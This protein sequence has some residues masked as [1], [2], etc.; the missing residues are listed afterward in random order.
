MEWLIIARPRVGRTARNPSLAEAPQQCKL[1]LIPDQARTRRTTRGGLRRFRVRREP[2]WPSFILW[3]VAGPGPGGWIRCRESSPRL[4]RIPLPTRT[5]TTRRPPAPGPG[6]PR[7]PENR[8]N[9]PRGGA[10]QRRPRGRAR[11]APR[12]A[13]RKP[14]SDPPGKPPRS[15][16]ASPPR[17]QRAKP[18]RDRQKRLP[19][20]PPPKRVA[21]ARPRS[22]PSGRRGSRPSARPSDQSVR[23]NSPLLRR[24][25]A[26]PGATSPASPARPR[27]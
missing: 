8:P 7:A 6:L 9:P 17:K 2:R 23:G 11:K 19:A 21:G 27:S 13:P 15:L 20:A 5:M 18:P 4:R 1:H 24:G 16:R 26:A 22:R 3:R 25:V 10:Q 14:P 12:K